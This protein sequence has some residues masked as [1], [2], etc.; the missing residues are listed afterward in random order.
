VI[1]LLDR[2]GSAK[3]EPE[4]GTKRCW[5]ATGKCHAQLSRGMQRNTLKPEMTAFV[6]RAGVLSNP[7]DLLCYCES[8]NTT[9]NSAFFTLCFQ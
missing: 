1:N 4:G 9:L 5:E 6:G 8:I 3:L 7:S 2:I